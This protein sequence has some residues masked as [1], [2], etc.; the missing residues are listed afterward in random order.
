MIQ[1]SLWLVCEPPSPMLL[2]NN[3]TEL[4]SIVLPYSV[5]FLHSPVKYANCETNHLSSAFL[6]RVSSPP[7]IPRCAISCWFRNGLKSPLPG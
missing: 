4:S 7:P 3:K 6:R 1:G 2:A 5:I